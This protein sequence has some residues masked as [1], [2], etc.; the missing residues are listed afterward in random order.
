MYVCIYVYR[1]IKLDRYK[2]NN[3]KMTLHFNDNELEN[4]EMVFDF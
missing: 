1:Y 4:N 3:N 2:R